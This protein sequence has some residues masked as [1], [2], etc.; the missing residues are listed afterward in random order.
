MK[1]FLSFMSGVIMGG[2]VGATI[3]L[4]LAPYSGETLRGQIRERLATLQDEL[5]EAA[6][7]RR[8]ELEKQLANLRQPK[9]T[10]VPLEE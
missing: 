8:M 7:T 5:T 3:A 10:S 1:K 2:L 4:L 6:S 9:S